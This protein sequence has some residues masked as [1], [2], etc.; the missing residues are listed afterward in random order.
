MQSSLQLFLRRRAGSALPC[1]WGRAHGRG[2]CEVPLPSSRARSG[3]RQRAAN[4][5]LRSRAW[6]AG[7][8][9][10]RVADVLKHTHP[11]RLRAFGPTCAAP[12][13]SGR[14][15]DP[16]AGDPRLVPAAAGI[17][18]RGPARPF[19]QPHGGA[20]PPLPA[21]A[22][23]G[24]RGR[25]SRPGG[26]LGK[27]GRR[28]QTDRFWVRYSGAARCLSGSRTPDSLPKVKGSGLE[29]RSLEMWL[30]LL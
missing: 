29:K 25:P 5:S 10:C 13:R 24:G 19:P 20:A 6:G 4:P 26:V 8:S 1:P 22:G 18:Q 14:P 11:P 23:P 27:G 21:C 2:H 28:P 15:G 17:P 16:A 12:R 7:P 9:G 3:G 30:C